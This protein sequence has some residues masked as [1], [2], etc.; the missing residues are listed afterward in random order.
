[1]PLTPQHAAVLDYFKRRPIATLEQLRCCSGSSHMTVFR[2]L[3]RHGYFTSF[4]H[5][6]RYYTL[7]QIPRFDARGLWFYRSIGFSQYR[8]LPDSLVAL[9]EAS[10]AGLL[11]AELA[12]ILRT[13]V[14]NL[15]A[16][17]VRQQRLARRCL[18]RQVVY[19][20]LSP[21][22]QEQQWL[23]RLAKRGAGT[24]CLSPPA[25]SSPTTVLP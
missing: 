23:H 12:S 4:N 2:A 5:N 22:R 18:G 25:N 11:A 3:K 7:R 8:T 15:L 10:A 1:M 24:A 21:P 20:A 16:R 9:V 13:P 14:T 17:L 6:A 19:L